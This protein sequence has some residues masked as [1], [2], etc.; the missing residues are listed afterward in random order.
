MLSAVWVQRPASG[1]Y[2]LKPGSDHRGAAEGSVMCQLTVI[3]N[4]TGSTDSKSK[5]A[6]YL[7]RE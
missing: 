3:L 6:I 2:K 4:F 1:R 7:L 5:T